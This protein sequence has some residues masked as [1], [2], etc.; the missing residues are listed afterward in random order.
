MLTHFTAPSAPF[1]A[2][3]RPLPDIEE[4]FDRLGPTP[5]LC[6]GDERSLFDHKEGLD[7][8]LAGLSLDYLEKLASR[9][10]D[11]E[12]DAVSHTIIVLR[13]STT[14]VEPLN[15]KVYIELASHFIASEVARWMR[16][17]KCHE[18]VSLFNRYNAL[19]VTRKMSGDIFE[20][21]CH[22]IFSM[23]IKFD[24]VSMVR[25]GE[26]PTVRERRMPQW[27]SSHTEFSGSA[28]PQALEVLRAGASRA[29]LNMYPSR[30]V[31]YDSTEIA[32]GLHIEA[33]VYYIPI[34][35]SQPGIDSFI[36]HDKTLYFFQMTVSDTHS[37]SDKFYPFL[38]S[39]KGLP[40]NSNWC[41]IFVK[42]PGKILICPVPTSAELLGLD[43][44]SAEVEVTG[45]VEVT[46]VTST[47]RTKRQRWESEGPHKKG[48]QKM[49][50]P[51]DE[52]GGSTQGT[53]E[54]LHK[55][56]KWKMETSL[57]EPGGSSHLTQG[58]KERLRKK[59]KQR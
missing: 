12:L 45:E 20:A 28:Q 54:G 4:I 37:I 24:F 8:A 7:K 11:L 52:L 3:D 46:E 2:P 43:L 40:P 18:L 10:N 13:R 34:K 6:F 27:H 22:V 33:N 23:R 41:F 1:L 26:H 5:R 47:H 48:K 14:D 49:E 9:I 31:D 29:S 16:A 42:P 51:G 39:L 25:I 32:R 19:P 53:K 58:T 36:L 56:G 15:S 30:V 21:Y 38:N 17:L 57:D 59:G 55:K 50:T 44:Y 35:T